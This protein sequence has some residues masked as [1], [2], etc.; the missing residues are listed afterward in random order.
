MWE[1][2]IVP[3][4][5]HLTILWKLF[6][7][8][9]IL[10]GAWAFFRF[11]FPLVSPF[12]MAFLLAYLLE[13]VVKRLQQRLKL[14]R[15]VGSG[16]LTLLIIGGLATALVFLIIWIVGEISAFLSQLDDIISKLPSFNEPWGDTVR[17]W[18][19]AAPVSMQG[20]LQNIADQLFSNG[21]TIPTPN[22]MLST[23]VSWV[24]SLAGTLPGI[25]L[26]WVAATLSTY[27]ISRDYPKVTAWLAHRLPQSLRE[28]A[29]R[30][31]KHIGGSV[32]K[33]LR[34]QGIM[35]CVTF[36]ELSAG[37]LILKVPYAFLIA[38]ITALLDALPVVGIGL[39]LLPWAAFAFISGAKWLG[40]GLL[41]I[42]ACANLVRSFVEPRLVGRQLGLHPLIT[43][44]AMY[45]GF[46][47]TGVLGMIL[48]PIL[49]ITLLQMYRW[50]WFS[51]F[52]PATSNPGPDAAPE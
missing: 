43:L 2:E 35:M 52:F 21:I 3:E 6:V 8:A 9:V 42:Y 19:Q 15:P 39:V 28:K 34:A 29:L 27:F 30:T 48:F 22:E 51:F 49:A 40:L 13:P 4:K 45:V 7:L 25:A 1:G 44:V 38:G 5:K 47:T 46:R 50:G 17:R 31:K 10:I 14:P 23:M 32:G 26:F 16:L 24:S 33:W 36:V 20:F 18:I 37:F 11:L 12:L 41:V